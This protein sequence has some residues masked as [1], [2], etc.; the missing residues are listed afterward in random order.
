MLHQRAVERLREVLSD[1]IALRERIAAGR[2]AATLGGPAGPPALESFLASLDELLETSPDILSGGERGSPFEPLAVKSLEVTRRTVRTRPA[3]PF[4][5]SFPQGM[6]WGLLG[7]TAAFGVSLVTEREH[8]TLT[9]LRTAPLAPWQILGG[10]AVACFVTSQLLIA[11]VLLLGITIFDVRPQSASLLVLAMVCSGVCFVGIMMCLSVLGRTERAA[12]GIAWAT[13]L[14]L[15][16]IGGGMIPLFIMP[17]WMR[18]LSHASPVKWSILSFEGAIWRGFSI[19]EMLVP[20]AILVGVGLAAFLLG[21]RA[22][23]W[24]EGS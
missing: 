19:G 9:R 17:A 18:Q 13:L 7:C 16:M 3:N 1:P 8:G 11:T 23:R 15:A 5:I 12:T 22:F 20:C 21:L 14:L 6:I 2:A 10:K 24:S 4:A